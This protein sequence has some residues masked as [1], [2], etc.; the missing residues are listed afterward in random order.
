MRIVNVLPQLQLSE[1]GVFVGN[2]N[3]LI[4]LRQ[5][6]VDG[7]CGPYSLLMAL[8][9]QNV[10]SR[11]EVTDLSEQDGRT[12]L[13]KF[14]NNLYAF[15]TMVRD[16]TFDHDLSWLSE[17]F[18]NHPNGK[19]FAKDLESSNT[20]G[21]VTEIAEAIDNGDPVIVGLDWQGGGAHWAV[22][23]GYEAF[24]EQV[25]KIMLLDPGFS[26]PNISYWN[27]VLSVAK[28]DGELQEAGR[29]SCLHWAQGRSAST[30]CKLSE[31]LQ[32]TVN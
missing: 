30:K 4:S 15:D 3:N 19:V 2:E 13:G 24:D 25:T 31:C 29:L 6:D 12:R 27:A 28:D 9:T 22:A 16:G 8:I 1:E 5:G 26:A 7:A 20:R 18:K 32:I 23:V 11:E 10:L 21:K 14:W 17:T